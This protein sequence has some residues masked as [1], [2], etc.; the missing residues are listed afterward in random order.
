[1]N[2]TAVK[3]E[4]QVEG[5]HTSTVRHNVSSSDADYNGLAI[6]DVTVTVTD[7]D[8]PPP[9]GTAGIRIIPPVGSVEV[10]EGFGEDVYKVVL[11][12]RPT[13]EVTLTVT[14][15]SQVKTNV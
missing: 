12:T 5:T 4:Q 15:G 8:F 6:S 11:E 3:D 1:M 13:A 14:A 9:V 7:N 2:V 10:L